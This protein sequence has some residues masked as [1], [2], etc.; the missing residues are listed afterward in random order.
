MHDRCY[1]VPGIELAGLESFRQQSPEHLE[2]R[3]CG[4]GDNLETEGN[5]RNL[6]YVAVPRNQSKKYK[7]KGFR[8]LLRKAFFITDSPVVREL[9]V[10]QQNP[11][12]NSVSVF[13]ADLIPAKG[14]N[15][16][17]LGPY[18]TGGFVGHYSSR[19]SPT[20]HASP[21]RL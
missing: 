20:K 2:K 19:L 7:S 8:K 11:P 4:G 9:S 1:P 5:T 15:R 18:A 3:S 14:N 17:N 10:F 16:I 6:E 12:Q 13:D 21:C